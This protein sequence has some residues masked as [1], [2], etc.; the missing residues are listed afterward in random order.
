[1]E[2]REAGIVVSERQGMCP[3]GRV[4]QA[5]RASSSVAPGALGSLAARLGDERPAHALGPS[6]RA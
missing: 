3:E 2:L 5:L 6:E 4:R 1:M